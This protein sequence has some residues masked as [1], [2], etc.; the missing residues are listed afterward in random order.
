MITVIDPLHLAQMSVRGLLDVRGK[1]A[2]L[3]QGMEEVVEVLLKV[4]TV[5][6]G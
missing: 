2:G 4:T 3:P 6:P 5:L 1:G